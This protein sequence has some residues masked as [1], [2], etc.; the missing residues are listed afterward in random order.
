VDVAEH[1]RFSDADFTAAVHGIVVIGEH[2][3]HQ[4]SGLQSSARHVCVQFI[5]YYTNSYWL[6]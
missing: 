1:S 5:W 4:W 2:I 6:L 3:V